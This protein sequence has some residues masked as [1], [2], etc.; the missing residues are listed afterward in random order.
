VP[1]QPGIFAFSSVYLHCVASRRGPDNSIRFA[2]QGTT[3]VSVWANVFW[4]QTT[5][6][7]TPPQADLDAILLAFSN[8]YKT[9]FAPLMSNDAAFKQA[10]CTFFDPGG[11]IVQSALALT[12]NGTNGS[13]ADS[14]AAASKVISWRSNVY[15]RGGKPRTYLAGSVAGDFS[16]PQTVTAGVRTTMVTNA[17]A[18]RTDVN[19]LTHGAI[20][21]VTLGFVSFRSGNADRVPPAFFPI[22][23]A[24]AHQRFGTQRRRLGPWRV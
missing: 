24:V 14:D 16:D 6:S 3:G 20:T 15:W 12:G 19:A 18:F 7:G 17:A 13:S 21:T 11:G 4:V 1:F 9:R 23:G 10:A 22:S 8:A 2:L 5:V